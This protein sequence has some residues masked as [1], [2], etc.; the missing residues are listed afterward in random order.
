MSPRTVTLLLTLAFLLPAATP[1]VAGSTGPS[2]GG[3]VVI[4]GAFRD[5]TP[6]GHPAKAND[7]ASRFVAFDWVAGGTADG[8]TAG[9]YELVPDGLRVTK[10]AGAGDVT[11]QQYFN[12]SFATSRKMEFLGTDVT[13]SAASAGTYVNLAIRWRDA[14]G[15]NQ[16][17]SKSLLLGPTPQTF[18]FEPADLGVPTGEIELVSVRLMLSQL[19]A[20]VTLHRVSVYATNGV[21]ARNLHVLSGGDDVL[22]Q[23][24]EAAFL[25]PGADGR[26]TF[27]VGIAADNGDFLPALD[28]WVCL[29]TAEQVVAD[30]GFPDNLPSAC[31]GAFVPANSPAV[32]R[33]R[34]GD[35]FRFDVDASAVRPP[36]GFSG[37]V[38]LYATVEVDGSYNDPAPGGKKAWKTGYFNLARVAADKAGAGVSNEYYTPTPIFVDG[39]ADGTPDHVESDDV[40]GY[41]AIV[42]PLRATAT[43]AATVMTP[44]PAGG[45]QFLVEVYAYPSASALAGG[46]PAMGSPIA[47]G[48]HGVGFALFDATLLTTGEQPDFAADALWLADGDDMQRASPTQ[49]LVTVPAS[50][51]PADR[52]VGAWAYHDVQ[53]G[54]SRRTAFEGAFGPSD[55][56]FD[57]YS[58]VQTAA[59]QFAFAD[60]LRNHVTP[61][62]LDSASATL[63]S[64]VVLRMAGDDDVTLAEGLLFVDA[65]ADGAVSFE[66]A[67]VLGDGSLAASTG[68]GFAL[69]DA[70]GLASDGFA[71]GTSGLAHAEWVGTGSGPVGGWYRVDVPASAFANAKGPVGAWAYANLGATERSG[72][73]N[74]AKPTVAAISTSAAER[75]FYPATPIVLVDS[76][77][78]LP[79]DL[80]AALQA[81]PGLAGLQNP[82]VNPGFEADMMVEGRKDTN[83][84]TGAAM[85]SPPWFFR[86]D[87]QGTG[88]S[89]RPA[90]THEVVKGAGRKGGNALGIQ[91]YTVD[92]G[93]GLMLGQL[94]GVEDAKAAFLWEDATGVALDVKTPNDLRLDADV[95]YLDASGA[96]R[97]AR[98]TLQAPG[99]SGWQRVE[100][101]FPM[102]VDGQL[103]GLYLLP[104]A[105]S[106]TYFLLD[107]VA[108]TGSR[109]VLGDTRTDLTD[110]YAVVIEPAQLS[111][112]STFRTRGATGQFYL[113]N[114]S[115]VQYADG[116]ATQ[117]DLAGVDGLSFGLRAAT[118]DKDLG[119][120]LR[121]RARSDVVTAVLPAA[122][123]PATPAAPWAF[124]E[125]GSPYHPLGNPA[126]AMQPASGYYS[127]L[128]NALRGN[129]IADRLDYA[130][131]PLTFDANAIRNF[132]VDQ[133][134]QLVGSPASGYAVKV[135]ADTMFVERTTLTVS[136]PSGART[137]QVTL[138]SALGNLVPGLHVTHE[139]LPTLTFRTA[140]TLFA[141]GA[142][143][144]AGSPVAGIEACRLDQLPACALAGVPTGQPIRFTDRTVVPGGEGHVRSWSFGD[145]TTPATDASVD[146]AFARP[147]T[148]AVT[149]DVTTV[150]GKTSQAVLPVEVANR[151][152]TAIGLD[153]S[154]AAIYVESTVKLQARASDPD[155]GV[156]A[157]A[158]TVEGVEVPGATGRTLTLTP[159]ILEATT[160][161]ALLARG[162]YSVAYTVTDGQGGAAAFASAFL[163]R[164]HAP[165][166]EVA[167]VEVVGFPDAPYALVGETVRITATAAD[168]DDDVTGVVARL[169][170]GDVAIAADMSFA[171]GAW[172]ADVTLVEA[173]AYAIVVEA[174]SASGTVTSAPVPFEARAD[175]AP[176]AAIEG[177]ALL[178]AFETG[179]FTGEAS[180]DPDARGAL[181]HVWLLD[182]VE[183]G[184]GPTFDLHA[185]P[186]TVGAHT[187]AL[188]VTDATGL[189]GT[190]TVA[191]QVDD[192]LVV[193]L[194]VDGADATKPARATVTVVDEQGRPVV[195]ALVSWKDF[196]GPVPEALAAGTAVTDAS[197]TATWDVSGGPAQ[198]P[199]G[200]RL[201]V[202]VEAASHAEAP[203][204]DTETADATATYGPGLVLP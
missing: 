53:G 50:E 108:L 116:A 114:V 110:G 19:D 149:L 159:A 168:A 40:D 3:D 196:V 64:T 77:T 189:V 176:V 162:E 30:N 152:P 137:F 111:G 135:L 32:T 113:F 155:G 148:Y 74:L 21:D 62:V 51:V 187:L 87:D 151:G 118:L 102:P 9:T 48:D 71:P 100:G 170:A 44:T 35:A 157:Y 63:D 46:A 68:H 180:A 129:P 131:A 107:N 38:A 91:Y 25:A 202:H 169:T 163:V 88:Q 37:A 133:Q 153:V 1:L 165:S 123:A 6:A 16:A 39:D 156:L 188:R 57:F 128:K 67:L 97:T 154:P 167:S 85:T 76:V 103:L 181:A 127:P 81:V 2:L 140:D 65:G 12:G 119:Q 20:P 55:S 141:R 138:D 191:F 105:W 69:Y 109:T 184:T 31:Q 33:T 14:L 185:A 194:A 58:S 17:G 171:G 11:L 124:V 42:T 198:L 136:S 143:V 22:V 49:F 60:G 59:K 193:T 8:V 24:G 4:N 130:G 101:L 145:G 29:Y 204:Q 186:A 27:L 93:K 79:A 26:Y 126:Y 5:G 139:E 174:T 47:L 200:H 92:A 121:L 70:P 178:Q 117:V 41:A 89:T 161:S 43:P 182:G 106:T 192:V 75:A 120:V 150:S 132:G 146:H 201:E 164:D 61:I 95:H 78:G 160:G 13:A 99:A 147:G 23:G 175:T 18:R 7:P 45:Y 158:W 104:K 83:D 80:T 52:A 36:T 183:V 142:T 54:D 86:L 56:A 166:A 66:Y 15:Q 197:G 203:V 144:V 115:L 179:A 195:G 10:T 112:A 172:V 125:A 190:T 82:L 94:L 73:Y 84:N 98:T 173:G 72:Y 34:Q 28:A 122:S 134:I 90:S 177:P 96:V 199:L